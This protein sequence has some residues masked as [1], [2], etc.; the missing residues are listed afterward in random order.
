M[1]NV[2]QPI[3]MPFNN[4]SLP[5]VM[6]VTLARNCVWCVQTRPLTTSTTV[7]ATQVSNSGVLYIYILEPVSVGGWNRIRLRQIIRYRTCVCLRLRN[8]FSCFAQHYSRY[9]RCARPTLTLLARGC[10]DALFHPCTHVLTPRALCGLAAPPR[11]LADAHTPTPIMS[12]CTNLVV[13]RSSP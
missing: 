7:Y 5:W 10:F 13:N 1:K 2:I 9:A 12:L 11:L 3:P 8:L 4:A 6:R